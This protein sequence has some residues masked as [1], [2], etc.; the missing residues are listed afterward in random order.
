MNL[1]IWSM[2]AICVSMLAVLVTVTSLGS[3][4]GS[5]VQQVFAIQDSEKIAFKKVTHDFEKAV[6]DAA[7]GNPNDTPEPHLIPR[8][9]QGYVDDVNRIFLG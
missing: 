8:L 5:G 3:I 1:Q 2:K 7:V 6:I 4:S 9:L